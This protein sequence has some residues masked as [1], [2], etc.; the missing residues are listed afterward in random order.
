VRSPTKPGITNLIEIMASATGQSPDEIEARFDGRGYAP[1][2]EAV[3]E[4]VVELLDP[5]RLRFGEL[6]GNTQQLQAILA[7]GAQKAG[8]IASETL[9]RAYDR[10]G[11]VPP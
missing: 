7:K 10:V 2:K 9:A 11:F 1:F 3:A 5:I 6:R 4:S 8:A